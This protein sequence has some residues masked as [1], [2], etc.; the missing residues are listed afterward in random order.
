MPEQELIAGDREPAETDPQM[1]V[2]SA[3]TFT[4]LASRLLLTS[5]TAPAYH[6]LFQ[7]NS[8]AEAGRE[9]RQR[10]LRTALMHQQ[11]VSPK[12]PSLGFSLSIRLE[13]PA[14]FVSLTCCV[15]S[16]DL[17]GTTLGMP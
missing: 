2:P 4:Y 11:T 10:F 15:S 7:H 17:E 6:C 13:P 14:Y 12:Q 1:V 3:T 9:V 16:E 5:C 8:K